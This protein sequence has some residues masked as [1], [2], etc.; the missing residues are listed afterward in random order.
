MAAIDRG[1]YIRKA[2]DS[3]KREFTTYPGNPEESASI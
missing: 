3:F 2:T 1:G